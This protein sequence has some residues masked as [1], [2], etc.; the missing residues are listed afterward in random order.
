MYRILLLVE[1]AKEACRIRDYLRISGCNVRETE[2]QPQL[3]YEVLVRKIDLV[4]LY[5]EHSER[6]FGV[7]EEMRKATRIPILVL[8]ENEDEW[9]KIRMFQAGA[10]DYLVEPIPQGELIARVKANVA[11]YRRL[12]QPL[13]YIKIRGLEVEVF[14]RRVRVDGKEI[15]L[16]ARE[17]DVLLIMASNPDRVFTKEDIYMAIWEEEDLQGYYNPVAVYVNKIRNKIEKDPNAPQYLETV[18][19]VGYRLRA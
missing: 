8:S 11:C 15:M 6:L 17:F 12:T 18:W 1:Q 3:D 2:I 10:D 14:T 5:C 9:A 13:G 16:T 7:C 19:G 4:V